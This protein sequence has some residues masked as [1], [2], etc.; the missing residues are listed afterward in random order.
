MVIWSYIRITIF[1]DI[2]GQF[3]GHRYP[4]E[5]NQIRRIERLKD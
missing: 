4:V 2:Y 3:M 5:V 1:F